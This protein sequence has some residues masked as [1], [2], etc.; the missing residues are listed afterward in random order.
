MGVDPTDGGP[1]V[2]LQGT[3]DTFA[4]PD[5][6]RLLAATAKTGHLRLEGARGSGGV[7]FDAG[8]VA[9]AAAP[10][11]GGPAR[12][13]AP[14]AEPLFELLRASDGSF[15][16]EAGAVSPLDVP[17]VDVACLLDEAEVLLDEWREVESVVPSL[18]CRVALRPSLDVPRVSVTAEQWRSLVAVAAGSTVE[19]VGADLALGELS[20]SRTV[21]ELLK[22][23]LVDVEG[24]GVVAAPP[25]RRAEP[26]P[27]PQVELEAE[28]AAPSPAG[29]GAAPEAVVLDVL[30]ELAD[31]DPQPPRPRDDAEAGNREAAPALDAAEDACARAPERDVAVVAPAA[32]QAPC[33]PVRP[34]GA[35]PAFRLPAP[36]QP[37]APD[38]G[39]LRDPAVARPGSARTAP[40]TR[41][42]SSL[43]ELAAVSA[44]V[45][46]VPDVAPPGAPGGGAQPARGASELG[47]DAAADVVVAEDVGTSDER[48]ATPEADEVANDGEPVNRSALLKFLSSVRT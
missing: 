43:A 31:A 38:G 37:V 15:V 10:R 12:P 28:V 44:R 22:A 29:P 32:T 1:P 20:A 39:S 6:L 36:P 46:Q 16:F 13:V 26:V 24:A 5:V 40:D 3:L 18:G 27:A 30:H 45:R 42:S 35:A 14:G 48:V 19:D 17:P 7:W 33:V 25:L 47:P 41:V 23:G 21:K 9:A 2:S 8:R 11:K 4:L 34:P